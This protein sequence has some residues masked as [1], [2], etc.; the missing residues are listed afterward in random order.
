MYLSVVAVDLES[1]G[2]NSYVVRWYLALCPGVIWYISS[3]LTIS[4]EKK[5]FDCVFLCCK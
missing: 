1:F 4:F 5:S 2:R 3:Y